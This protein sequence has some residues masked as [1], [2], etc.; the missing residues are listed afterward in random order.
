MEVYGKLQFS[1]NKIEKLKANFVRKEYYVGGLTSLSL[2]LDAATQKA[3]FGEKRIVEAEGSVIIKL[4][5]III[6]QD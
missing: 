5:E 2:G 1:E 4:H 3:M 6:K